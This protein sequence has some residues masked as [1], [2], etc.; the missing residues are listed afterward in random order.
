MATVKSEVTIDANGTTSHEW[1]YIDAYGVSHM[2]KDT[3]TFY[4]TIDDGGASS[5]RYAIVAPDSAG[6][7]CMTGAGYMETYDKEAVRFRPECATESSGLTTRN[8]VDLADTSDGAAIAN[9]NWVIP[10]SCTAS[11]DV[12]QYWKVVTITMSNVDVNAAGTITA[13]VLEDQFGN[14]MSIP[15]TCSG[16]TAD[17]AA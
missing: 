2:I 6:T 10:M 4:L 3:E 7:K 5:V 16:I 8:G 14:R 13:F 1:D 11:A 9:I 17:T 12:V 15:N